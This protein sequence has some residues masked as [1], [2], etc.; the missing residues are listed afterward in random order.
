MKKLVNECLK[1]ELIARLMSTVYK[2]DLENKESNLKYLESL[3]EDSLDE[4]LRDYECF[5]MK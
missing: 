4:L 3:S 1:D 2:D 5:D